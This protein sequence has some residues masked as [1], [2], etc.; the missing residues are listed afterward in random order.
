MRL[1][2]LTALTMVAFAANSVLNRVALADGWIGPA[3][4]AALRLASGAIALV[5]MVYATG[6]RVPWAVARRPSGAAA[7]LV[8]IV[9]FS[10]AYL[11]LDT[12][13]GALILFGGV[14]VTMFAGALLS[15]ERPGARRWLGAGVAFA[16]LVW[17]SWPAGT[18]RLDPSGVA[19]M[20]AAAVGWGIYSLIG[21]GTAAPLAATAA[22]FA[23]AVPA[24]ALIW[25]I[26][27]DAAALTWQ[28]VVLAVT[29]G[30]VTSGMGYALWYSV[31]P[32][33][34]AAAAALAQLT[35][36][37]IAAAGGALF[38]AEAPGTRTLIAGAL[39]LAGVAIGSL[40]PSATRA[41]AGR[42]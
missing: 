22:N 16:G 23:L 9:G 26:V 27:P 7:L 6:G 20:S 25:L 18:V 37:V 10:F 14:Q 41:P 12:G 39:V 1:L 2:M 42:R 28:G 4:F 38:L 31:L 33:L 11:T 24:G 21:R 19:L 5:L 3:D 35:V 15:G 13:V 40:A 32:R 29:S 17:L 34:D 36:P 30:V 8:Y